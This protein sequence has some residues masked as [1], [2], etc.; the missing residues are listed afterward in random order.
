[1]NNALGSGQGFPGWTCSLV[2]ERVSSLKESFTGRWRKLSKGQEVE[3]D[4]E[5][6]Y[7]IK[8]GREAGDKMERK[9]RMRSFSLAIKSLK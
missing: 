6:K 1:M 5:K 8:E 9:K 2:K 4:S 3:K 7:A